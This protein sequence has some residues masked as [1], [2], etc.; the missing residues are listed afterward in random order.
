M[1][2]MQNLLKKMELIFT[3][4]LIIL[5]TFS[6][7]STCDWPKEHRMCLLLKRGTELILIQTIISLV[8]SRASPRFSLA[9]HNQIIQSQIE[10]KIEYFYEVNALK[11]KKNFIEFLG[12][13]GKTFLEKSSCE[14]TRD[15]FAELPKDQNG[16]CEIFLVLNLTFL[17]NDCQ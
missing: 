5:P 14:R 6:E 7:A 16:L 12:I 1:E 15:D 3:V 2:L 8:M 10:K 11:I 17:K 9:W 4:V 13:S